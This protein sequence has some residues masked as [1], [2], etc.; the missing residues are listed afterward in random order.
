MGKVSNRTVTD[1]LNVFGLELK[2]SEKNIIE[3]P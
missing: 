2:Q 1:T 3:T